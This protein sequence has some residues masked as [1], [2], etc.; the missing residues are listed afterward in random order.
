LPRSTSA[1]ERRSKKSASW[2]TMRRCSVAVQKS[3]AVLAACPS[4]P[5]KQASERPI[6]G[7]AVA[8]LAQLR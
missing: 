2:S 5:Q 3:A 1:N 6:G 4:G 8:L 7:A